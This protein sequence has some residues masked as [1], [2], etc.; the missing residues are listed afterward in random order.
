LPESLFFNTGIPT[1][2][3]M[4]SN[5]KSKEKKGKIQLIDSRMCK[6]QLRKNLG[7]K[8]YEI[9]KDDAK[10]ILNLYNNNTDNGRSK[11]LDSDTFAYRAVTIQQP[12]R[13]NFQ[14][15]KE[16]I[17]RLLLHNKFTGPII[18]DDEKEKSKKKKLKAQEKA[19]EEKEKLEKNIIPVLEKMDDKLYK[20]R[21]EFYK[22]FD[23]FFVDVQID[24]PIK[25]VVLEMLSERDETADICKNKKGEVEAD[26]ELKDV[27]RI[28][29]GQDIYEYFEK[30]VKPYIPNAWIDES[31][32]DGKDGEIGKVG[33]EVPFTRFF[34]KYS[35]P[36]SV[37]EIEGEIKGLENEIQKILKLI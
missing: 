6:K 30:E 23:E 35:P 16:R 11:I 34:Y 2:I 1:Y 8:R 29:F 17:E 37:G 5:R 28:P 13:L 20:N 4:F 32:K 3:W 33:Y 27:E 12:L 9:S 19:R 21:E 22:V 25:K 24:N 15:S 18:E 7:N 10:E 36:R 31:V 14:V 26:K